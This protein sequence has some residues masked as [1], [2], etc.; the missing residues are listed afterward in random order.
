MLQG[1]SIAAR[2]LPLLSQ[3]HL[4]AVYQKII[5]ALRGMSLHV[6]EGEIVALLGSN[7]P[8]DGGKIID[9]TIEFQVVK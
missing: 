2:C 3:H 6:P 9:R 5:I 4:E 8:G 1:S 7:G